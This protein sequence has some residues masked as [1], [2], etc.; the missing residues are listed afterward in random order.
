[1]SVMK[2]EQGLRTRIEALSESA[3][4]DLIIHLMTQVAQLTARVAELEA[5][6]G[7]NSANSSK[8]PSSE[9]YSKPN[10]KSLREKSGR[11]P[12]GQK[13][14]VGTNLRQISEPDAVEVHWPECCVCGCCLDGIAMDHVERRQVFELPEKLLR[15]TEHRI[16][17]KKCPQCG[18]VIRA[19]AP[20]ETSGPAQYGPRFRALLVYLRD[21]QLLPYKRLTELC[22]DLLGAGVCKRTVER[23][24]MQ[25]YGALA[26]FE[27]AVRA[28]LLDE[29]VLHAD[30]TG[31]RVDGKLQW[32]HSLSTRELTLYQA[33]PKR[34]G[35]A[36]EAN[37]IIPAFKGVL[38]HDCWGPY[39][40]YGGEHALC[41]A[42]LLRELLGV[43]ENEGH[44]WA[45]ELSVLLEMMAKSTAAR[46]ATPLSP[47]LVDWFERMYDDILARGK[48]GL[49]PPQK[50]PGKR[51]RAK[52][53]KSANLHGRLETHRNAVLRFL[54][55]PV[56]P[57]TN[58]RAER[59]IRMVKLRQKTSGCAR[60]FTG[61]ETFARIRSYIST[62]LKQGKNL[63]Q[64]IV[65]TVA[66]NPWI[67][68]PRIATP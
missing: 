40:R 66:A 68:Q 7:M 37:G 39:F 55:D 57:F 2:D 22:R 10:P 51:G 38:V 5:R 20:P 63:F 25:A 16:V 48:Q 65:D 45:Y 34:G 59:D 50:T 4:T 67:P 24:E 58:N 18:R 19:V 11:K 9:G 64:N 8:P 62:S 13:G 56:V 49:A 52:K 47:E 1:M 6:L 35:E 23:A 30:E 15:V 28:R 33:H 53:S 36:I 61:A 60:S 31:M 29:A 3:K 46:E 43:C 26:P 21:Y 14:H 41:G 54:R 44:G 32:V 17:A 27:E 12:G 42:H